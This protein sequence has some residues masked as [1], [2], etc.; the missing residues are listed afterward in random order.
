[1]NARGLLTHPLAEF[2]EQTFLKLVDFLL[3]REDLLLILLEFRGD[4][5]L[6]SNQC[7]F[8]D[9]VGRN[10]IQMGLGDLDKIAENPVVFHLERRNSSSLTLLS[11][12]TSNEGFSR[13][14]DLAEFIQF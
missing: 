8:A 7:L 3:G 4:I 12:Q 1:M 5:A 6:G 13:T 10:G 9:V 11:F 14:R 2:Y